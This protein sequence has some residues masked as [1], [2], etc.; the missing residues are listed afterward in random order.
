MNRADRKKQLI[1]QGALHRA[2]IVL[3]QRTTQASLHPDSLARSALRHLAFTAWSA[4]RKGN[5]GGLPVDLPT[6]LPLV[7]S[8]ISA[9]SKTKPVVKKIVFGTAIACAATSA[10]VMFSR[11]KKAARDM[12]EQEANGLTDM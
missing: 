4:F 3:A 1:A 5:I 6:L 11:K 7:M 12:P 9:L 2:E 8:G 10:A